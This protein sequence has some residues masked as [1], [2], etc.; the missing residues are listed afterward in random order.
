MPLLQDYVTAQAEKQPDAKAVVLQDYSLSYG[1]LESESN[2]LAQCLRAHGCRRGDRVALLMPKLP[3]TIVA[4]V[5]T[6]KADAIYVPIDPAMPVTRV[7]KILHKSGVRWLL[8]AG[9]V[10]K[11]VNDIFR[12]EKIG[13]YVKLGWIESQ[14]PPDLAVQPLITFSEIISSSVTRPECNNTP[15]DPAHILFTSGSTGDPKGVVITHSNVHH[16][17]DWGIR[18]FDITATDRNSGQTPLHFDLSTFD[19]YGTLAAGAELHLVPVELN[20]LPHKLAAFM[21]EAELTQ[22]FSVPSILN[23]MAKFDAVR[24]NDFPRM[25]RLL[26][27][28]EVLPTPALRYWMQKL[29][30]VSFTNLYG[31]TETTIASSYYTVPQCPTHDEQ[32]IPIGIPCAGE[33]LTV[34]DENLQ[35]LRGGEIGDLYISGVGLSPGYWEDE[36]KTAAAFLTVSMD[37]T[38]QRMYKT[39]DLASL[40]EDSLLHF[41]GRADSQIKSRGYRIELG[42]IEA[43]LNALGSLTEV[44]VVGAKTNSFEGTLICCAYVASTER[45]VTP[46][47]LRSQLSKQIPSYMLPTRWQAFDALPKNV[48]GKID[49]KSL[50]ELFEAATSSVQK[51]DTLS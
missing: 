47:T 4:I 25:K 21:R 48:N 13:S 5:A 33:Q 41:H 43:A 3:M 36:E 51:L 31:P 15:S 20:L 11:L 30:H 40:S 37:G 32:P 10:H 38:I 26:W 35:P 2:R 14:K 19:I 9:P 42:E 12:D 27:C 29:P 17:V 1:T 44:A 16:F 23:Y 28:G 46:T 39:G 49:R 45:S 6:L 24:E 18:H 50:K 34:L 22:W 7:S 8:A